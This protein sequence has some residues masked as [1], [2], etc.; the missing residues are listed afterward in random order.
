MIRRFRN[1]FLGFAAKLHEIRQEPYARA[2]L[3]AEIQFKLVR[4][5]KYLEKR[6]RSCKA[7]AATDEDA[8]E[9]VEQYRRILVLF[10]MIGDCIAFTYMDRWDVK[11]LAY[12]HEPGFISGKDGLAQELKILR[13][14]SSRHIPCLLADLTNVLRHGDL[15]VFSNGRLPVIIEIK[16]PSAQK[17]R[18]TRRQLKRLQNLAEFLNTDFSSKHYQHGYSTYRIDWSNSPTYYTREAGALLSQGIQTG[19]AVQEV[20][21]GLYYVVLQPD[22]LNELAPIIYGMHTPAVS[23]LNDAVLTIDCYPYYPLLLSI[24]ESENVF[25]IFV[26]DILFL[27]L[28]DVERLRSFYKERNIGSEFHSDDRDYVADLTFPSG[29]TQFDDDLPVRVSRY[30][31]GRVCYEFLSLLNWLEETIKISENGQFPA[32][33]N[34]PSNLR[35][36]SDH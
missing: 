5:I 16:S 13:W 11:P 14:A 33:Q 19:F 7:A 31:F 2:A 25:R 35:R 10:R 15:Y 20:E 8:W 9:N 21:P 23:L 34:M 18:R 1:S 28:I 4:Q 3:V 12:G 27:V 26:W 29:R 17:D 32:L 24:P 6:I 36:Q 30:F 22:H